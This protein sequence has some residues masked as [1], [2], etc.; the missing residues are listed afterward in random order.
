MIN[1][2]KGQW[3]FH[4]FQ[5]Q[6]LSIISINTS[7]DNA[8]SDELTRGFVCGWVLLVAHA[9]APSS[10]QTNPWQWHINM[11]LQTPP[12]SFHALFF[13]YLYKYTTCITMSTCLLIPYLKRER[14]S[15]CY[16]E[17]NLPPTPS[18]YLSVPFTPQH[19]KSILHVSIVSCTHLS[20][21]LRINCLYIIT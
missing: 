10:T 5:S 19:P 4:W 1:E 3:P 2:A 7:N 21:S 14:E 9:P 20:L 8:A 11:S 18:R 17:G 12:L 13:N 15:L 6:C 16:G